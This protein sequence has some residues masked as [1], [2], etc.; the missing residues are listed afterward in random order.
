MPLRCALLQHSL[1]AEL[2]CGPHGGCVTRGDLRTGS[3]RLGRWRRLLKA[4]TQV[5]QQR[6]HRKAITQR[7]HQPCL[8]GDIRD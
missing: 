3:R 1:H 2:K 5:R 7:L 8:L 6:S 4:A